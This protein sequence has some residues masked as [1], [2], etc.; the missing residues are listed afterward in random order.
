MST[1]T[2]RHGPVT[3]TVEGL[4]ESV[5][6]QST[7]FALTIHPAY[8]AKGERHHA[9]VENFTRL[10]GSSTFPDVDPTERFSVVSKVH[11]RDE[12]GA[13]TRH[14]SE[15]KLFPPEPAT[16]VEQSHVA[17][18][19]ALQRESIEQTADGA[20]SALGRV[21]DRLL[22]GQGDDTYDPSCQLPAGH[23]PPCRP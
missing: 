11:G 9:F 14:E 8:Y 22:I 21:C 4:P 6:P 18:A 3:I 5:L 7:R 23:E 13:Q 17:I 20:A 2:F 19:A 15:L 16:R 12:T 1:I 10:G